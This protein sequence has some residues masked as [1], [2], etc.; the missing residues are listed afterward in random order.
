M[1]QP[2]DFAKLL[3]HQGDPMTLVVPQANLHLELY[4]LYFYH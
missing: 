2:E 4:N 1:D 3:E